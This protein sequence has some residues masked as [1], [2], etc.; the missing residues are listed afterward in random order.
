MFQLL[1][2]Y[3]IGN[4][5]SHGSQIQLQNLRNAETRVVDYVNENG[6]WNVAGYFKSGLSDIYN[7][8]LQCPANENNLPKNSKP[9]HV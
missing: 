3:E 4:L 1:E 5:A 2:I 7:T 9:F 6:G 8:L